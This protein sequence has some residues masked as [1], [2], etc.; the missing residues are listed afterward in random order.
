LYFE[1]FD[2]FFTIYPVVLI[3]VEPIHPPEL[4]W[5]TADGI[6]LIEP[7]GASVVEE[8]FIEVQIEATDADEDILTYR[9]VFFGDDVPAPWEVP[10]PDEVATFDTETHIFRWAAPSGAS[11]WSPYPLYFEITDGRFSIFPLVEI[12]VEP[13]LHD[14]TLYQLQN[15][16]HPD[17]I[18]VGSDVIVQGVIVTGVYPGG[19]F[20]EEPEAGPWSGIMVH[21]PDQHAPIDI[22]VG[23]EVTVAGIIQEH[24]GMT[25]IQASGITRTDTGLPV[26]GPDV[27]DACAIGTGGLISEEFEGVLV[28]AQDV[29]VTDENPDAPDDFGE[30][31]VNGCLR[32][33]DLMMDA[34]T[35]SLGDTFFSITGLLYY[36]SGDFKIAPRDTDDLDFTDCW[37]DDADSY[38]DEVCGGDDCDDTEADVNPGAEEIRDNFID[39]DCDGFIDEPRYGDLGPFG[40]GDGLWSAADLTISIDCLRSAL[41]LT[42]GSVQMLD[43]APVQ[44]CEWPGQRIFAT[45]NPD[46][47][48]DNVDLSVLVQAASGYLEL[49]PYCP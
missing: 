12:I 30:F 43:V 44:V 37:D 10:D 19:L 33:D 42:G 34:Y 25:R 49:V 46:G 48:V 27:V 4:A 2:G 14:P 36:S 20:V 26:P 6:P 18:T 38:E 32:V 40:D 47:A 39:D 21:D 5:I 3:T 17:H 15:P 16:S 24:S 45:P 23:D 8:E 22:A 31:E 11:A 35:P 7:Y 9:A 28:Q 13:A 1:V 29:E 41:G